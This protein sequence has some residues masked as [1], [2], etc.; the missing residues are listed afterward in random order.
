[1]ANYLPLYMDGDRLT[2]VAGGTLTGGQLVY[3]SGVN[4]VS[5]TTTATAAW[6]GVAEND[7]TV[8]QNVTVFCEGVQLLTAS[9]GITAGDLVIA[10]AAGAVVTIGSATATTDSQVVG[11]ALTTATNGNPV[12]VRLVA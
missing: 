9:G 4:T 10:G 12:T 3:I 1:M 11:K 6:I 5:A 2:L 7:A 8:G